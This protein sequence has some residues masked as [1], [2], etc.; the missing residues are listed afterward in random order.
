[1]ALA[2]VVALVLGAG[3][4]TSKPDDD[5]GGSDAPGDSA[6]VTATPTELRWTSGNAVVCDGDEYRAGTVRD[7]IPGEAIQLTSPM[8]VELPT[9]RADAEGRYV[10]RWTCNPSEAGL[11]WELTATGAA[12]GRTV[13]FTV[14]GAAAPL[15]QVPIS[16]TLYDDGL[17]CDGLRH[18]VGVVEGLSP[19]ETVTLDSDQGGDESV[20]K[21]G[22]DGVFVV[23]W[24]CRTGDVD[25]T[26]EVTVRGEE[27]GRTTGFSLDGLRWDGDALMVVESAEP[28]VVCDVERYPVARLAGLFPGETV[29][30]ASPQSTGVR[31][32]GRA[33]ADGNLD[34]FW[35][36]DRSDV[37]TTWEVTAT[38]T[39][40]GETTTIVFTGTEGA[41]PESA[42]A[43]MIEDPFV[44]DGERRPVA[45]IAGFASS[46]FVDFTSPQAGSLR[47]GRAIDAELTMNWQCD[48]DQ[49]G[50]IWQ[51]TATG[52]ES[53]RAV[54]VTVT[55]VAPS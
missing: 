47:E 53:G 44:C 34:L 45:T 28:E 15:E 12:S 25:Q 16:V 4:T 33:D 54:T 42:T 23:G 22:S 24:S 17:V 41:P 55:G 7:A 48:P 50:T 14:D 2:A 21:A 9:A 49:A 13:A 30:F 27:T 3:C 29:T 32:E 1:M 11:R 39:E 51:V 38:A 35:S 19:G 26:W 20:A 46:E 40:G 18:E 8:P 10:L 43:R 31:R 5:A 37:G 36:C 6:T 52:R